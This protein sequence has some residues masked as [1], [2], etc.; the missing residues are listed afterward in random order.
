MPTA[1]QSFLFLYYQVGRRPFVYLKGTIVFYEKTEK[2][3]SRILRHKRI[4]ILLKKITKPFSGLLSPKG[5]GEKRKREGHF[6]LCPSLLT[7]TPQRLPYGK[8][9]SR[10]RTNRPFVISTEV[11]KSSRRR[12]NKGFAALDPSTFAP[13]VTNGY[14]AFDL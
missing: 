4:S 10:V 11:E 5:L 13:R 1:W 7:L 9:Q 6:R 14:S 2:K 3:Y 8:R 12:I